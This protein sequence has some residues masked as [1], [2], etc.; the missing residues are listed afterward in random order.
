MSKTDGYSCGWGV[1]D[2]NGEIWVGVRSGGLG[3]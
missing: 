2:M 1:G 3:V